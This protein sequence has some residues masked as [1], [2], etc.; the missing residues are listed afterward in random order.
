M[1]SVIG[2][3]GVCDA[4]LKRIFGDDLAAGADSLKPS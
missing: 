4:A 3:D 2:R 1:R